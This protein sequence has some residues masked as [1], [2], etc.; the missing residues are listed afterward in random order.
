MF[1][2]FRRCSR[3]VIGFND[4]EDRWYTHTCC[5]SSACGSD[6]ALIFEMGF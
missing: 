4:V 1:P 2:T 5:L 3:E 6:N